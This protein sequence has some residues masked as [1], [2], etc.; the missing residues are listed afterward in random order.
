MSLKSVNNFKKK[1]NTLQ[2]WNI[3]RSLC[4]QSKNA[5]HKV[6]FIVCRGGFAPN[7]EIKP[8]DFAIHHFYKK[9]NIVD[10]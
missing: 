10:R 2:R 6:D 3:L 4:T 7:Q 5:G 1:L 8:L 9:S